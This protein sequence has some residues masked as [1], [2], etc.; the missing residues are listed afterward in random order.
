MNYSQRKQI[1]VSGKTGFI[2]QALFVASVIGFA[3]SPLHAFTQVTVSTAAP[4][5]LESAFIASTTAQWLAS[6]SVNPFFAGT[7]S[8]QLF[9]PNPSYNPP[10]SNAD[11]LNAVV[12]VDSYTYV[13]GWENGEEYQQSQDV[14][15]LTDY[16]VLC[17]SP[18][19]WGLV[20]ID[21][22]TCI[23]VLGDAE[24][25]IF[26]LQLATPTATPGNWQ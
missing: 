11:L 26:Q 9:G 12:T 24:N 1:S 25:G 6:V 15:K 21:S 5:G 16:T 23:A 14:Q 8:I 2:R 19:A 22:T 13:Y 17:S 7:Y 18:S 20:A 10:V 4:Q 3:L